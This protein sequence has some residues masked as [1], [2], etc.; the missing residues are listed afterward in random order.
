M[1]LWT[2]GQFGPDGRRFLQYRKQA[3]GHISEQWAT[4]AWFLVRTERNRVR[5]REYKR[6]QAAARRALNE[7]AKSY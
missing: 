5:M 3:S 1:T 2:Y 6:K 7:G 4:P